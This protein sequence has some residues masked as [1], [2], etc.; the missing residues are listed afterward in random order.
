MDNA[1]EMHVKNRFYEIDLLRL[2]AALGVVSYHYTT[3]GN[4]AENMSATSA[5][6][7]LSFDAI[8]GIQVRIPRR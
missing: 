4:T 7:A 3:R 5:M 1:M 6:S 8:N 2:I